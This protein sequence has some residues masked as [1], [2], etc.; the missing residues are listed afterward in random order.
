MIKNMDSKNN[1]IAQSIEIEQ[2]GLEKDFV[3]SFASS[4]NGLQ[5]YQ[6]SASLIVS[7]GAVNLV[8]SL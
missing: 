2:L 5:D 6:E 3:N 8:D 7:G 4:K 1:V